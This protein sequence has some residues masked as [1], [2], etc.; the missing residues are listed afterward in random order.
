VVQKFEST[1]K[2]AFIL[3]CFNVVFNILMYESKYFIVI[4]CICNYAV[5]FKIY[6]YFKKIYI[7]PK[8]LSKRFI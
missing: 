4:L 3:L 5:L 8:F 6:L 1:N 7:F 2:N